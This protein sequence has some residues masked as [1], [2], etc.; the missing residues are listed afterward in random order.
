MNFE[1]MVWNYYPESD[2]LKRS[3]DLGCRPL[4]I[5]AAVAFVLLAGCGQ[6]GHESRHSI[7][8][9]KGGTGQAKKETEEEAEIRASRAKLSADDARLVDAQE[10]CAVMQESRLGSMGVP[11]KVVLKDKNGKEQPFFVCCK[12]CVKKAQRDAELTLAKVEQLKAKAK[13]APPNK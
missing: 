2:M 8:D 13:E 5:L 6:K 3:I 11:I 12:G 9:T 4:L 1:L 7:P 10:F